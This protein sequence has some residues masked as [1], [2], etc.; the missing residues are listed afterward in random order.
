MKVV[1]V[2]GTR[3]EIIKLSAL[4]PLLDQEFEHV[5]VHTGQ[6][7]DYNMDEVFFELLKLKKPSYT[8]NI[9]S[10]Q[11]GK[12]TALMLERFE[13]VLLKEKPDLV[14]VQGDTNTALAGALA[15]VKL[16]VPVMHVEA[17]CRSFNRKMPEE[18]NRVI[19]DHV[20]DYLIAPDNEC[21]NH[22]KDEGIAAEKIKL[23][24][25]TAFEAVTKN[26]RFIDPSLIK[27]LCLEKNAFV[28]VTIH[29]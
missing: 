24:G 1:T 29:R 7:Y 15:A 6:H 11:Q 28:L 12:Q 8:L 26:K 14:I 9:G 4:L 3:P 27:K 20:A 10:H 17:G 22:L 23:L 19:A 2:L 16:H 18:I 13:E 21:V 5:L 25:S